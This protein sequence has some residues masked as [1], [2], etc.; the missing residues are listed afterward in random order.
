MMPPKMRDREQSMCCCCCCC[1]CCCFRL[2]IGDLL[3]L[4]VYLGTSL[5]SVDYFSVRLEP[6]EAIQQGANNGKCF[7]LF[8]LSCPRLPPAVL[9]VICYG[10]K[11]MAI[12]SFPSSTCHIEVWC[13]TH[14]LFSYLCHCFHQQSRK[15]RSQNNDFCLEANPRLCWRYGMEY[16]RHLFQGEQR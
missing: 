1:C 13:T 4:A 14:E 15:T 2:F 10:E 16:M 5:C 8:S 6:T 3:H 12:H 11:G 9:A 7:L